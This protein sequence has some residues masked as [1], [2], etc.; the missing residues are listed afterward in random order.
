MHK[1]FRDISLGRRLL[2][3]F[4]SVLLLAAA[5]GSTL[6][7]S[8]R[9]LAEQQQSLQRQLL[10]ASAPSGLDHNRQIAHQ[11]AATQSTA[12]RLNLLAGLLGLGALLSGVL[13]IRSID[14]SVQTP[15]AQALG[16]VQALHRGDMEHR[17]RIERLD[18]F[19]HLLIAID[20]LGNWLAPVLDEEEPSLARWPRCLPP[21]DLR[22]LDIRLDELTPSRPD[23]TARNT[24]PAIHPAHARTAASLASS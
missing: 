18:E 6:W 10:Q 13:A 8:Q 24:R 1:T 14:R 9:L 21:P 5:A 20:Q 19:G 17:A 15:L 23:D 11:L 12:D 4:G 3:G 7:S 22:S 16:A 2:L